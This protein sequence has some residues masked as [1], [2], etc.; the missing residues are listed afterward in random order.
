MT[1]MTLDSKVNLL[2]SLLGQLGD[3][4]REFAG[5][6]INGKWGYRSRGYLSAKQAPWIDTLLE[7]AQQPEQQAPKCAADLSGVK[8]FLM[9][10]RQKLRFPKVWLRTEDGRD[11]KVY[12]AGDRSK[13]PNAVNFVLYEQTDG[14]RDDTWLGRVLDNGDWHQPRSIRQGDIEQ[15]MPLL[16]SLGSDPHGAAIRFAKLTGRCCFCNH[17]LS[18][19]KHSTKV[20]YGPTCAKK[21]GLYDEWKQAAAE[22]EGS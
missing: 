19:K 6:L 21:F 15:V 8:A 2:E 9:N 22:A 11:L 7:R 1:E 18:D 20:G 10:A 5:S 12:V 17:A 4:D 13:V 3:S 16:Q 14:F